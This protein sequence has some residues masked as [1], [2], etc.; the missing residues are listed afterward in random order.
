MLLFLSQIKN[1]FLYIVTLVVG[2]LMYKNNKLKNKNI[3]VENDNKQLNDILEIKKETAEILKKNIDGD[4]S[5][6]IKRM[7]QRKL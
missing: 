2:Y 6:N 4:I 3:K 7:H 1:K 5:V